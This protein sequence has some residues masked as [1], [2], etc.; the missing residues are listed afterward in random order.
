MKPK[1]IDPKET[2]RLEAFEIS[3]K[4]HCQKQKW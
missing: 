1:V 2:T 3:G 4:Y